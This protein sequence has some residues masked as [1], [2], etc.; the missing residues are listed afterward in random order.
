EPVVGIRQVP[1]DLLHPRLGRLTRDARDLH[2]AC[3]QPH[4]E[5][6]EVADESTEGQH[7]DREEVGR[8]ERFPVSGEEGA[9]RGPLPPLWGRLAPAVAQDPLHRAAPDL[10]TETLHGPADSCVAPARI[11]LR[12]PEY[13]SGQI[14]L[15]PRTAGVTPPRAVVLPRDEPAVPA[16]YGVS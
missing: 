12:H 10:V 14:A 4:H 8:G 11:L 6:D 13:E 15:R 1:R 5:E 9:P 16:Q 7:F 2:R 3:L